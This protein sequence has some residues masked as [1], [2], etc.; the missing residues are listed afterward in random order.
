MKSIILSSLVLALSLSTSVIAQ[1]TYGT[2]N[3]YS[4]SNTYGN[5]NAT[6]EGKDE[7][8]LISKKGTQQTVIEIKHGDV[9]VNGELISTGGANTTNRAAS[10][11]Y[12][13]DRSYR[14][15]N[16]NDNMPSKPRTTNTNNENSN[17]GLT[18][19]VQ[20]CTA[21]GLFVN[22][23]ES[24]NGAMVER[25]NPYTPAA[26]VGLQKGDLITEI[27]NNSVNNAR[28]LLDLFERRITG[29]KILITYF[30]QEKKLK[31]FTI[32][33]QTK[34]DHGYNAN[35]E[36]ANNNNPTYESMSSAVKAANNSNLSS[37]INNYTAEAKGEF[38]TESKKYSSTR[39]ND[40]DNKIVYSNSR[41]VTDK[42]FESSSLMGIIIEDRAL[43]KG[44]KVLDVIPNSAADDAG[45]QRGDVIIQI[46]NMKV[47]SL[48]DLQTLLDNFLP[49]DKVRVTY[50]HNGDRVQSNMTLH[51]G[52]TIKDL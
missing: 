3:T 27:D 43:G 8:V 9:Y 7:I 18:A 37:T 12:Q 10:S 39:T 41:F 21:L 33:A 15:I 34:G 48:L 26:K 14:S 23:R 49:N 5:T 36:Y 13:A 52:V 31:S 6:T 17:G 51:R 42:S 30:R 44:V 25:V 38:K 22:T 47:Y 50:L 11:P 20:Y 45:I 46:D 24:A 35:P 40:A 2:T 4:T 29:T 19:A 1:N 32:L 16:V 28:E